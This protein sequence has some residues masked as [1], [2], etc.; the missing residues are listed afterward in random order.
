MSTDFWA[1][2]EKARRRT[3]VLVVCFVLAVALLVVAVYLLVA[4][5]SHDETG[6]WWHPDLFL[7]VSLGMLTVIGLGSMVRLSQ[8]SAGGS[9]VA[10]MLGGRLVHPETR[11]KDERRLVNVVQEMAIASG[12]PVPPVYMMDEENDVLVKS[13]MSIVEP[14]ILMIL[15]VLV[16]FVALSM[17][18]PLFDLMGGSPGASG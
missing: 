12:V 6:S 3:G 9:V 14:L 4:L 7:F 17:F 5:G 10:D 11:D 13:L 18:M 8:L 15:G 1:R 16:G 2:Q